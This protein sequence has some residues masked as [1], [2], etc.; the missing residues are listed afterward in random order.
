MKP[1]RLPTLRRVAHELQIRRLNSR[2]NAARREYSDLAAHVYTSRRMSQWAELR[3][4]TL[5]ERCCWLSDEIIIVQR[6]FANGRTPDYLL[7]FYNFLF[8][9]FCSAA[10]GTLLYLEPWK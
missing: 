1:A 8:A 2:L 5:R 7:R 3:M 6:N 4:S 9:V 10:V